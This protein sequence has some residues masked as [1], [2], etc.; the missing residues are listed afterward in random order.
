MLA[1]P[2]IPFGVAEAL[3]GLTHQLRSMTKYYQIVICDSLIDQGH[4]NFH[5][6][7]PRGLTTATGNAGT[8]RSNIA[9]VRGSIFCQHTNEKA[10][11]AFRELTQHPDN[12]LFLNIFS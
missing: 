11:A 10:C 8:A 12:V 5:K 9:E 6:M 4:A 2:I 1:W 7:S 3:S